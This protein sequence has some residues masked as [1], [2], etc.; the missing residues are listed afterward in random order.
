MLL[1]SLCGLYA[2]DRT[3]QK[4]PNFI[5]IFCDNLGYGDIEPFGSTLHRTPNLNRMAEEGRTFTHFKKSQLV[6]VRFFFNA[7][8][9]FLILF[10]VSWMS[11]PIDNKRLDYF[12]GKIYT[13]IR[14]DPEEDKQAVA[15]TA[16]NPDSIRDKK[17]FP[18]SDWEFAKPD[19]VDFLGFGGSC[20]MVGV[21]IFCLW[22]MVTIGS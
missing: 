22:L 19:R 10:I 20:V 21:V 12:I 1:A 16:A 5:I 17:L 3:D 7:F 9:P 11:R 8:F 15:F 6:A 4:K 14:S 18:G 13:P 2:A